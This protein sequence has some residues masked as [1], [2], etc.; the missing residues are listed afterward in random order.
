MFL[1]SFVPSYTQTTQPT[2]LTHTESSTQLHP[3]RENSDFSKQQEHHFP[4]GP[5]PVVFTI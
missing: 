5:Y 4:K 2:F 3:V 1:L